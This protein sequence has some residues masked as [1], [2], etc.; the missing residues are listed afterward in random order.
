MIIN[1]YI[2]REVGITI[3]VIS[4]ILMV[5]F[6]TNQFIHYMRDVTAGHFTMHIIALLLMLKLPQLLAALLPL[7]LYISILVIYGRMYADQEMTVL[8]ACGF[9]RKKL[10]VLTLKIAFGLSILLAI[11]SMWVTPHINKY[12][13]KLMQKGAISPLALVQPASFQ[14]SKD[15]RW[16]FYVERS[17]QKK[18]KLYN[19]FAA[20]EPKSDD[21]KSKVGVLSAKSASPYYDPKTHDAFLVFKS[22]NRYVGEAGSKN[23]QITKFDTYGIRIPQRLGSRGYREDSVFT[24]KLLHAH[25]GKAAAELQWRFS[26]PIMAL[27]LS[28]IAIP[29]SYVKSRS[30][31][32]LQL[33]PA[34]LLYIIYGNFIFLSRSWIKAGKLSPL[35]GMWWV[36]G[37]MLAIALILMIHQ[38]GWQRIAHPIVNR[39]TSI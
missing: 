34:I 37:L 28:L 10:I 26:I 6:I 29:L 35:I 25:G 9:S 27:V 38:I 39:K 20:E 4:I 15:G 18:H 3:A 23:Y 14:S 21:D 12:A 13:E 31:R 33:A 19:I 8:F 11:L 30:H 1:R 17:N 36:H 24:S 5:V 16:I 32:Y 7:S 2:S 22:G